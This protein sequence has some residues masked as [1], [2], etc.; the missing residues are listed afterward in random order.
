M[1]NGDVDVWRGGIRDLEL[2]VPLFD[3]YRQFYGLPT[4]LALCRTFLR[5][6]I[7][8][9]EAVVFIAGRQGSEGWGFTQLYPT[10]SSLH[11]RPIWVLYDLFVSP[12]ARSKGVG[13]RLMN[14]ARDHAVETGAASIVLSTARTNKIGQA[15][16]ES[17]GYVQDREFLNYELMLP[18]PRAT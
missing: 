9:N 10:F 14:R 3:A 13:R 16:Y 2:L 5:D 7:A 11:A 15:L 12:S 8:R 18:T 4:D 1:A 17:L 6:R